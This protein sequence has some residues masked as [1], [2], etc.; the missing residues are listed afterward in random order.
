MTPRSPLRPALLRPL[1]GLPCLLAVLALAL[2]GLTGCFAAKSYS[3]QMKVAPDG[4]YRFFA[5]GVALHA[6]TAFSL[7]KLERDLRE[8]NPKEKAKKEEEA[9]AKKAE[10]E[11]GLAKQIAECLKD[12]RV[13]TMQAIGEGRVRFAVSMP[14]TLAG[15][16]LIRREWLTPVSLARHAD[17]SV[18]FRIKDVAPPADARTLRVV[19][20]GDISISVA[21]GVQVLAHNA[22]KVPSTP[23]GSYRWHIGSLDDP[24]PFMTVLLPGARPAAAEPAAAQ[25]QPEPG[26]A[27]KGKDPRKGHK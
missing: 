10:I 16:D 13:Q 1:L 6:P 9:K 19:P 25:T 17:G 26:K 15:T 20:D 12:P 27:A 18:T 7:R 5:E 2:P 3:V 4:G 11:S 21:E 14:G 22:A 8:V 24:V 23:S